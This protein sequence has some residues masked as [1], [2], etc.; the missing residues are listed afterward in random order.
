MKQIAVISTLVFSLILSGCGTNSG[1]G[2]I[3]GTWSAMLTD[4]SGGAVLA[5]TTSFTQGSGTNLNVVNFSFTTSDACLASDQVTET[6][7]FGFGGDFQGHVTGTF[8]MVI[9]STGT[10]QAVL[11]LQGTVKNGTITGTWTLTGTTG[12]CSGNGVFTMSPN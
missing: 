11:T 6:G 9:S 1:T 12:T 7:S 8:G 4:T 3:N 10:D 2:N 5:F